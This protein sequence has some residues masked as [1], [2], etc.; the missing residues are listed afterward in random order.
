MRRKLI[1][2]GGSGLTCYLPKKW[3]DR[4]NLKSGQEVEIDEEDNKILIWPGE[5]VAEKKKITITLEFQ[6]HEYYRSLIGGLYRGG[7]DEITVQ[8]SNSKTLIELQKIVDS[9]YGFEIFDIGEKTCT[10]KSVY[11][12]EQ[13]DVEGSFNK[14]IFTI[15]LMH[16]KI[17]TPS[18]K[19][20]TEEDDTREEMNNYKQQILKQRDLISRIITKH[21][22][23]DN[24][25]FPYYQL[26][27]YLWSIARNYFYLYENRRAITKESQ[28]Y[29]VKTNAFFD[30]FF[31]TKTAEEM[32][33]KRKGYQD[34]MK[35]GR[36]LME[37]K[38]TLATSF[39]LNILGL[40]ES[41]NSSLVL[42]RLSKDPYIS[43]AKV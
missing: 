23:V 29:I 37:K 30:S 34:L 21:K 31:S 41:C 26:S 25:H 24:K 18:K 17:T 3:I 40:I 15:K 8:F 28:D 5:H 20:E 16:Q 13:A 19:E 42:I 39:C 36:K 11:S 10:I 38:A 2:Q 12:E 33:A 35:E 43:Q 1:K 22:L 9:L 7:Y 27:H 4:N 32:F 6:S 14:M